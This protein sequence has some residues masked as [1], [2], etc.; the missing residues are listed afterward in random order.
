LSFAGLLFKYSAIKI[1]PDGLKIK[2][3]NE[4][5]DSIVACAGKCNAGFLESAR[6]YLVI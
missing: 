2:D 6:Y 4:T 5:A 1:L 3:R